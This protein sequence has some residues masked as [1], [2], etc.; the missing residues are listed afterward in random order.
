MTRVRVT[1]KNEKLVKIDELKE[2]DF[3]QGVVIK[4][5]VQIIVGPGKSTKIRTELNDSL[6]KS[7]SDKPIEEKKKVGV[8]KKL[9]NIFVPTLP[10]IIA[11]EI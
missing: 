11:S 1:Y 10:A 6:G 9:S 4:D 3:V 7:Q 2:L 5:T 8:L